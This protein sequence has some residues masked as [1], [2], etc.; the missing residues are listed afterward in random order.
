[1]KNEY[2]WIA[3]CA[4]KRVLVWDIRGLPFDYCLKTRI[5]I[6]PICVEMSSVKVGF[7]SRWFLEFMYSALSYDYHLSDDSSFKKWLIR[8]LVNQPLFV[9]SGIR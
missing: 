5:A 6:S 4:M 9:Y 1:M 7:G 8:L 2:L 3:L